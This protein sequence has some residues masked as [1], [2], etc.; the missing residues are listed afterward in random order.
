MEIQLHNYAV[1]V[2]TFCSN[3]RLSARQTGE[4]SIKLRR[5]KIATKIYNRHPTGDARCLLSFLLSH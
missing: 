1:V 3:A 4:R 5:L 2:H